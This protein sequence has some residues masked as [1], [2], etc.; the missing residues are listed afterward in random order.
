MTIKALKQY[1]KEAKDSLAE[2]KIKD[3]SLEMSIRESEMELLKK[4]NRNKK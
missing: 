3:K 1:I 4:R 2:M